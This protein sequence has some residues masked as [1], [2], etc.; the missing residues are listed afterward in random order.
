MPVFYDHKPSGRG[1][2]H[3]PDTPEK[4]GRDYVFSSPDP[5]SPFRYG[6]SY[7]DFKYINLKISND[8]INIGNKITTTF[9]VKNIS[10]REGKEVVQ[11]YLRDKVA[12]VSISV[13]RL[14]KFRKINL[15]LGE[16][17]VISFT[18]TQEDL[19]LCNKNMEF[20][21]EPGEFEIMIGSS[22]EDIR[23]K[24]TFIVR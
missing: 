17:R 16:E 22:A 12:T 21:V 4:P 10:E 5:L 9:S 20:V 14:R 13:K 6:L 24:K 11:L 15:Q 8:T 2:Y 7:T 3:Q 18:L 1:F 19:G 23:V